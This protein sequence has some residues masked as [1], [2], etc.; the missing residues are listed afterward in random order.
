MLIREVA[1]EDIEAEA[2]VRD[3]VVLDAVALEELRAS[4]V[5]NGVRLPVEIYANA[6]GAARPYALLSGYRR[7]VAVRQVLKATG[8]AK[9]S[10]IKAIVRASE[11][12]D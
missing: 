7:L 12:H 9:W 4:I 1:L 3:R 10:M 11:T 5:R 2:L 6:P 8:D